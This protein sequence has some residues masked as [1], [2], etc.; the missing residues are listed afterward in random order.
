MALNRTRCNV[1]CN[2]FCGLSHELYMCAYTQDQAAALRDAE[3][4]APVVKRKRRTKAEM[5]LA[6]EQKRSQ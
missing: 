6:A 2:E 5:E 4:A 3:V 1:S